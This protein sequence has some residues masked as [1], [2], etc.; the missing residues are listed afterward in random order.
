M[1]DLNEITNYLALSD[2]IGTAGQ[3][4]ESQFQAVKAAGY[5]TVINLALFSS[6]GA[7]PNEREVVE[8]LG[9]EFLHI[10]VEWDAPTAEDA[11][12]FFS[13]MDEREGRR[14]FVHCA[15]NMRVSAFMHLY[16]TLR[17]GMPPDEAEK[18][19]LR[20]WE[21]NDRWR[22]FMEEVRLAFS[23]HAQ[24]A[25]EGIDGGG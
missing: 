10:P 19:L 1:P 22:A 23:P 18:D 6:T 25:S 2:R 12:R 9:M 8:G 21:P 15:M 16:R 17:K 11:A 13:A 4:T 3:P 20:I 14:V 24:G 5:E 7:L